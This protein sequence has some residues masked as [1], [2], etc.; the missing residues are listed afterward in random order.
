MHEPQEQRGGLFFDAGVKVLTVLCLINLADAT[1]ER[2]VFLHAEQ[3]TA[4]EFILE[5]LYGL[6][7]VLISGM[8]AFGR[9][10]GYPLI[11]P[12]SFS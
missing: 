2:G 3:V 11:E 1:V 4:A 10:F 5:T 9:R 7:C 8:E 6:H 12:L